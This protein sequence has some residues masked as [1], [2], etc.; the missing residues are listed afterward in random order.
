MQPSST[1]PRILVFFLPSLLHIQTHPEHTQTHPNPLLENLEVVHPTF[2][3]SHSIQKIN[4]SLRL[5]ALVAPPAA[6]ILRQPEHTKSSTVWQ[7]PRCGLESP[8]YTIH[9]AFTVK[10]RYRQAAIKVKLKP[11]RYKNHSILSNLLIQLLS[12]EG[13]HATWRLSAQFCCF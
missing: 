8:V 7:R 9:Q 6:K 13:S 3:Y 1:W 11:Q 12:T 10:T 2:W 4:S 5:R